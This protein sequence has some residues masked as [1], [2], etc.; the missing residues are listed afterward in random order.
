MTTSSFA[1][2]RAVNTLLHLGCED[3]QSLLEVLEDYFCALGGNSLSDEEH[4]SDKEEG[5]DSN[6]FTGANKSNGIIGLD[7]KQN[8]CVC[9]SVI[10]ENLTEEIGQDELEELEED[11]I[12]A[13]DREED[14][15]H[16]G[17]VAEANNRLSSSICL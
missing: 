9:T 13:S 7:A 12:V 10:Q 8:E 15:N 6:L 5:N 11:S 17:L 14:I 2:A 1:A 16:D 3:Q 4:D